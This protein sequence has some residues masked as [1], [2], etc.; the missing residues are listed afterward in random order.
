MRKSFTQEMAWLHTWAGL[1]FGW[2]LV[3]IFVTGSICVFWLELNVWAKPE[4][5]ALRMP[6]RPALV[7]WSADYLAKTAPDARIWRITLP[8]ADARDPSLGLSW[9]GAK[10]KAERR[11]FVPDGTGRNLMHT[12]TKGG[13]LF[14]DFHWVLNPFSPKKTLVGFMAVGAAS[15][16]FLVV[17]ISGIVIHKRIFKDFF[18]FRPAAKSKQRSWLDAHNVLSVLPLPFHLMIV[19]TGLTY[20]SFEYVPAAIDTL[21]GGKEAVFR[22]ET[23]FA[24]TMQ[25]K[26]IKPGDPAPLYPIPALVQRAEAEFGAGSIN[27]ISVRDP[28]RSNAVVEVVRRRDDSIMEINTSR[29]TF[30]GV[31][32]QVTRRV[33]ARPPFS[34]IWDVTS[35][36]HFAFFGGAAMR[37]LYLFCGMAGAAMMACG[38]LVFTAKRREKAAGPAAERFYR[39]VDRLNVAAVCSPLLASIVHLWAIRLIPYELVGRDT[40]EVHAFLIAMAV[41]VLHALVRPPR[42]AWVEQL[43]ATGLLCLGL[44]VLGFLVPNSDLFSMIAAGDWKTAGVDLTAVVFGAGF[45]WAAWAVNGGRF[46]KLMPRSPVLSPAE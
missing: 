1:I 43:G 7:Q 36:L 35:A 24:Q 10:G 34:T 3:P 45:A 11:S 42:N 22:A 5:H 27:N 2:L 8:D 12:K 38:L 32:G 18:T 17:C 16:A 39:I 37:F 23:G 29:M 33:V 4:A 28:G 15:I 9:Q 44:P 25:T 31:S 26:G 46:A 13:R 20:F 41:S 19:F 6:E 40:W 14:V 21:Y 30:D